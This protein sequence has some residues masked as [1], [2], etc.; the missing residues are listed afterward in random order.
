VGLWRRAGAGRVVFTHH[1]PDR[2]GADPDSL[3]HRFA[4]DKAGVIVAAEGGILEP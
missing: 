1:K 4:D 3:A 2:T